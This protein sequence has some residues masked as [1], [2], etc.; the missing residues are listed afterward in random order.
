M[1]YIES[2]H[3]ALQEFAKV[4]KEFLE[5]YESSAEFREVAD[6]IASWEK[7]KVRYVLDI[8]ENE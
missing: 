6:M 7:V 4:D 3:P 2:A 8:L 5:Y 1:G